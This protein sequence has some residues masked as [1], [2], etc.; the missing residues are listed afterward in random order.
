MLV[1][2]L[3]AAAFFGGIRLERER[4]RR[5]DEAAELAARN[6][7]RAAVL[8]RSR[9]R[10]A[11]FASQ[12]N[13][14][15]QQIAAEDEARERINRA[16]SLQQQKVDRLM[17]RFNALMADEVSPIPDR[18]PL[19]RSDPAAWKRLTAPRRRQRGEPGDSQTPRSG[20]E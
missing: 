10:T 7:E 19:I 1:A 4:R 6:A 2:M 16:L 14:E 18:Q 17:A 5:E 12:Q 13:L 3:V 9:Q 11:L 15:R 20:Q 8:A